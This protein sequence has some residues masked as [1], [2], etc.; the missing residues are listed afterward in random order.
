[1]PSV[2]P[3][4]PLRL[5]RVSLPDD[6]EIRNGILYVTSASDRSVR[7]YRI[8]PNGFLP[9]E[10]DS[11]TATEQYYSDIVLDGN[12]LYAAAYNEGRIDLYTIEPDGMLPG[13]KPYYST[14][15]DTAS[16][17]SHMIVND[18]ILYVTQS[19]LNRVDAFVVGGDG[20]LTKYPTSSTRPAP[21]DSVPLDLVLYDTNN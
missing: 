14:K 18:G 1:M 9:E 6:M 11:R 8:E 19:G 20:L 15:G 10:Q 13:D 4:P 5:S 7:A 16:Y 17:P 12:T 2:E 21:G 3:S